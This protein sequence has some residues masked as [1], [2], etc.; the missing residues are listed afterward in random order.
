MYN[1]ILTGILCVLIIAIMIS[2][3]YLGYSYYKKITLNADAEEF[4]EEFDTIVVPVAEQ[5]PEEPQEQPEQPE[6]Q[7]QPNNKKNNNSNM[8]GA[9]TN[10]LYYKGFKVVGKLEM[11]TIRIQYPILDMV[12]NVNA[13]AIEVSIGMIYGPGVN[14]VGNT[15]IAGHNYNNGLFFGKNKKLKIGDKIYLTDINGNRVEYTIYNKYTTPESD[16]S[17][18]TRTTN[19][20]TEVTLYT[21]DATGKNRLIV[22]ARAD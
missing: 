2:V 8:N 18:I 13:N 15:V 1:K 5:P 22:C 11:P 9:T 6:Q 10:G 7:T 14:K 16:T 12:T 21:C 20:K 19:G 3:G 17:Y 4:L